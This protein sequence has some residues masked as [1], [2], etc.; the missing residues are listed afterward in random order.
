MDKA[1]CGFMNHLLF[2]D[3]VSTANSK[4]ATWQTC[5]NLLAMPGGSMLNFFVLKINYL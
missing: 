4:Y 1:V 3:S 5:V 2:A